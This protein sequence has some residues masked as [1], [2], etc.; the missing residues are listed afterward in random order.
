LSSIRNQ[1]KNK[2]NRVPWI[3]G[4]D[5]LIKKRYLK[6]VAHFADRQFFIV[7]SAQK[8]KL[9]TSTTPLSTT[10]ETVKNDTTSTT[11]ADDYYNEDYT[12]DTHEE[13]DGDKSNSTANN[14]EG[15]EMDPMNDEVEEI[16]DNGDLRPQTGL[17]EQF[18]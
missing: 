3:R 17:E 8:D 12:V 15:D 14:D 11:L 18:R 6:I 16:E 13:Q 5:S 4:S 7:S 2:K 1:N 10:G 9:V